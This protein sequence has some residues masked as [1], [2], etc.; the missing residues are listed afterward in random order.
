MV[1]NN[2]IG[3]VVRVGAT[4]AVG[5]ILDAGCARRGESFALAPVIIV[6]IDTLRADHLPAYGYTGVSTPNLDA[7]RKDAI[8][9]AN[10]YSHVPL[11]LPAHVSLFTGL[12]PF[13]H[14]VRDNLGYRLDAKKHKALAA[15]FRDKGYATGAFVSAHVLNRATGLGEGFDS[16]DDQ[17]VTPEGADSLAR[18][19]RSGDE[20]LARA[21]AW[22]APVAHRPFFL[23]L[24]IYEP[25]MPY[26]P[27]EPFKTRY[28]SAYDGE[29]AKSDEIVGGLV[30]ELKRLGVYDKALVVVL[31]DHGEGLGDHGEGEH[32]ILLYRWALHVPLML[33]LPG[34]QR[35][36]TTI[37]APVQLVDLVPTLAGLLGFD[38]PKGLP[39]RPLLDFTKRGPIYAETYYPRI[40]LGWSPLRSVIND[41]YQ[42]IEGRNREL[43]DFIA[44]PKEASNRVSTDW[45]AARGLQAELA[46]F[47]EKQ[48]AK[49][50]GIAAAD[51]EKLAALGYLGGVADVGSGPLPDPRERLPV[52]AEVKSAF[53]LAAAGRN[54]E[55]LVIF[56]MVLAAN[57]YLFDAR[58][59]MGQT[60]LRLGRYPE[61][62]DAFKAALRASPSLAAP[63]SLLLAR[64]CL[65][66]GN[67]DEAQTNARVGLSSNPPVAHEL[68]AR[69]ALARDD[70]ATAEQEAKAVQG[71]I[72]AGQGA[73][74]VRAEIA[75]RQNRFAE[76]LS[77]LDE[78]K[79]GRG[80]EEIIPDV[81]F[82][83]GDALARLGRHSDA[84]AAFQ[85]EIA[86]FPKN[87]Q[88][89]TRLAVVYG[90]LGKTYGDVDRLFEAMLK[91]D[92]RPATI[93]LA[94]KTLES[95]GDSQGAR[96]W[97]RKNAASSLSR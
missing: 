59:E 97:R 35:A 49:P 69:I 91:A 62:Y 2:P 81:D 39:G 13:D 5:G 17:I 65:K 34:S 11:T 58:F 94:A 77:I 38:A 50:T 46:R 15:L 26:E 19:Q 9:F 31:S 20:S 43:Y 10:A 84:E 78:A 36:G 42:Y 72:T 7:L 92:P 48:P 70:L 33:K 8:L 27:P 67:L 55:A 28:A 56:E 22:L 14:G 88:A 75:I 16:Y 80:E 3:T 93:E 1:R 6:S 85:A 25:H 68:L 30:G 79:R 37:D 12:L 76:A 86:R 63:L 23:F 40:H 83:R 61:A 52:L 96:A 29:I 51:L 47:P 53:R 87:T 45:A 89:Y 41:R 32:G 21:K 24:H 57:P 90:L 95:M 64:T 4:L 60:L 54:E 66:M 44:D 82:L 18:A 73:A 71:D 74:V